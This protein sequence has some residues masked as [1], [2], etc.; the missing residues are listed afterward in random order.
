MLNDLLGSRANVFS[1][2]AQYDFQRPELVLAD[3]AFPV[4]RHG[5]KFDG[6]CCDPPYGIRA[7]AK[8]IGAEPE[9]VKPVMDQ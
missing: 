4:W 7:G 8:K 6:I 5:I 2:F 3:S 1:N 9:E